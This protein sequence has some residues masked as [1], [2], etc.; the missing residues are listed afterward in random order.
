[1]SPAT[2]RTLKMNL[3]NYVH[4]SLLNR[5]GP[6]LITQAPQLDIEA[7]HYSM[8]LKGEALWT[9]TTSINHTLTS[10]N[11]FRNLDYLGKGFVQ[12]SRWTY[13]DH[14]ITLWGTRWGTHMAI[15]QAVAVQAQEKAW[16]IYLRRWARST[17]LFQ[18]RTKCTILKSTMKVV[19]SRTS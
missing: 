13:L 2:L 18:T 1:M 9:P 7:C 16:G 3:W 5:M 11:N 17:C 6:I 12:R 4:N 14:R 15:R 8:C 10:G 19:I